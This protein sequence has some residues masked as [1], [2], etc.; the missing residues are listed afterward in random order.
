MGEGGGY[1]ADDGAGRPT[2][3]GALLRVLAVVVGGFVSFGGL[4]GLAL[5]GLGLFACGYFRGRDSSPR[6]PEWESPPA[7]APPPSLPSLPPSPPPPVRACDGG[8]CGD[9]GDV[10][11]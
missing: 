10:T 7:V 8:P 9:A 1:S 2:P 11:L 6:P 5:L 3:R 4:L